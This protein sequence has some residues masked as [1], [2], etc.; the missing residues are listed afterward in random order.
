[1]EEVRDVAGER[2]PAR[3]S[4]AGVTCRACGWTSEDTLVSAGWVESSGCFSS[5][6]PRPQIDT[7]RSGVEEGDGEEKRGLWR[8]ETNEDA[9]VVHT[10][11]CEVEDD[12]E[13]KV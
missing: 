1:M 7:E 13:D 5:A 12:V 10:P 3:R 2:R 8:W 6:A 4:F 11:L 9:R